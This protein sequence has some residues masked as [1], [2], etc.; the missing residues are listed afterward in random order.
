MISCVT[1]NL[2]GKSSAHVRSEA[3]S[4]SASKLKTDSVVLQ[5]LMFCFKK[6]SLCQSCIRHSPG[7]L[8]FIYLSYISRNSFICMSS[9]F[10]HFGAPYLLRCFL[11]I[12]GMRDTGYLLV[13]KQLVVNHFYC[14]ILL[15]ERQFAQ[16]VK[17]KKQQYPLGTK[18]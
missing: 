14:L 17:S 5:S 11:P 13:Q 2:D 3:R 1:V 6:R 15:L 12:G 18:C 8:D 9:L 7:Y 10:I 4:T 16:L